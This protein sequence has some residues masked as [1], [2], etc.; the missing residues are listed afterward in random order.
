MSGWVAKY[1]IKEKKCI[2][3]TLDGVKKR[4]ERGFKNLARSIFLPLIFC[5]LPNIFIG[6]VTKAQSGFLFSLLLYIFFVWK[7]FFLP[8]NGPRFFM[9]DIFFVLS[10]FTV[11]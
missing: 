1:N 8:R 4:S 5:F 3:V 10:P 9:L 7:T 11:L 6:T 2:R